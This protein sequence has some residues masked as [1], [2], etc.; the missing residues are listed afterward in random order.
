MANESSDDIVQLNNP[1]AAPPAVLVDSDSELEDPVAAAGL[2]PP[3]TPTTRLLRRG[4]RN[5]VAPAGVP[6]PRTNSFMVDSPN[7]VKRTHR[8]LVHQFARSLTLT[9]RV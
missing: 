6:V 8:V 9:T 7:T 2:S 3:G 4:S 1:H 5:R